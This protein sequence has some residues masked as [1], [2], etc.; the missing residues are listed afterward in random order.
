M[1]DRIGGLARRIGFLFFGTCQIRRTHGSPPGA[2]GCIGL[3]ALGN[4]RL[5][6]S[7]MPIRGK[8]ISKPVFRSIRPRPHRWMVLAVG[9]MND[10]GRLVDMDD[11]LTAREMRAKEHP[12]VRFEAGGGVERERK[13][14]TKE[15]RSGPTRYCGQQM[16]GVSAD[17]RARTTEVLGRQGWHPCAAWASPAHLLSG[18]GWSELSCF[19]VKVRKAVSGSSTVAP[20]TGAVADGHIRSGHRPRTRSIESSDDDPCSTEVWRQLA[21]GCRSPAQVRRARGRSS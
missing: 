4:P 12:K 5:R 17:S 20:G 11:A 10:R 8:P 6:C 7:P 2:S 14:R 1:G 13:G 9:L 18:A 16:F 3:L 15:G 21:R 19:R